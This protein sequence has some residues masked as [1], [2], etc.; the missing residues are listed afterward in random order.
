MF[1]MMGIVSTDQRF[2]FDKTYLLNENKG[3]AKTMKNDYPKL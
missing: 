3:S 2:S 1:T